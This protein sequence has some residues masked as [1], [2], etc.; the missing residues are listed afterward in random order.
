MRSGILALGILSV[1]SSAVQAENAFFDCSELGSGMLDVFHSLGPVVAE[2]G[3]EMSARAGAVLYLQHRT[4]VQDWRTLS[5]AGLA[6]KGGTAPSM[7]FSPVSIDGDSLFCTMRQD[8][9]LFGQ[10]P[11]ASR[12]WLNCLVDAD[13]DG[14]FESFR[15][16]GEMVPV[17]RNGS[18]KEQPKGDGNKVHPLL[19]PVTLIPVSAPVVGKNTMSYRTVSRLSV[20]SVR[21]EGVNFRVIKS[22]Q[23]SSLSALANDFGD[24][25]R[26]TLPRQNGA[27]GSFGGYHI[28]LRQDGSKWMVQARAEAEPEGELLCD[29]RAIKVGTKLWFVYPGGMTAIERRPEAQDKMASTPAGIAAKS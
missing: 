3:Q 12:F 1:T 20:T 27:E 29:G 4:F 11:D 19:A 2:G 25:E 26:F 28:K 13:N 6:T 10:L 24:E 16:H 5:D 22:F 15:R 7:T 21:K 18:P 17:N 23:Y 14:R 8:E 9:G